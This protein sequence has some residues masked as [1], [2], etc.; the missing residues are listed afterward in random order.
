MRYEY[1]NSNLGTTDVKNIVDKHYGNIF[2]SLSIS[3][4][5]D[6][7]NSASFS[8]SRRISRPSFNDLAPYT[9]YA[10]A[11]TLITGNPALQPSVS[12]NII[13]GYT[14]KRYVLTVSYSVEKNAIAAFQPQTDSVNNKLVLSPGNLINQKTAALVLSIPVSVAKWW[15]MQCNL[16]TIWQ[17]ENTR[18]QAL[19]IQVAQVNFA[20]NMTQHFTLPK[21]FSFELSG[22]YKSASYLGINHLHPAGSLDMGL[23]KKLPGRRGSL[24]FSGINM[25]NTN[26]LF[27]TYDYPGQNLVGTLHLRFVAPAY[28][29]TYTRSFGKEKLKEKRE[30]ES[31]AELERSRVQ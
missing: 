30:R 2:P 14:F 20:I 28:K 16:T 7:S 18:Y 22:F 11:N 15:D 21:N 31:G 9:Y 4:K 12:D 13:A 1:T 25:L 3:H 27:G 26:F 8:Y 19:P 17:Q 10:N 29:L 24:I 6:E 5:I 23:K